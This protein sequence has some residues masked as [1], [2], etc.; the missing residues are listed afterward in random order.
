MNKFKLIETKIDGL[1]VIEPTVFG[2]ERGYFMEVYNLEAFKELGLNDTF[3][4]INQSKSKKGV[5]RGLH[6]QTEKAQGKLVNVISGEIFDVAVDLR[7]ESDTYG[8][9]HGI[10]LSESNKKQFYIPKG[11]AHGFLVLSDFAEI[12]YKCTDFYAPEYESGI[13]WN[14]SDLNIEWPI[15]KVDEV[16]L[17]DKDQKWNKFK[18]DK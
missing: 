2:D 14:D 7:K 4:Q 10:N 8:Q 5:L 16:F 12:Q 9:W 17:S 6:Y 3:V 13:M 15:N 18:D 1:R 11:F